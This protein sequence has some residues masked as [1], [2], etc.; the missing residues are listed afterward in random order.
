MFKDSAANKNA[1]E[2]A[3]LDEARKKGEL[4]EYGMVDIAAELKKVEEEMEVEGTK[5]DS[6]KDMEQPPSTKAELGGVEGVDRPDERGKG[7]S[8]LGSKVSKTEKDR[9][10]KKKTG[11]TVQ[12]QSQKPPMKAG[13]SDGSKE[14]ASEE[15]K[16]KGQLTG[17][18]AMRSDK[19][20]I[21]V[22]DKQN[23]MAMP[24]RHLRQGSPAKGPQRDKDGLKKEGQ[25]RTRATASRRA[26]PQRTI[27]EML[28]A[29]S[30][31]G[32]DSGED[33]KG[34]HSID[35][36]STKLSEAS[37]TITDTPNKAHPDAPSQDKRQTKLGH[38]SSTSPVKQSNDLPSMLPQPAND[39]RLEDRNNSRGDVMSDRATNE[40]SAT[41]L[42]EAPVTVSRRDVRPRSADHSG[43]ATS[44]S[45]DQSTTGLSIDTENGPIVVSD[46]TKLVTKTSHHTAAV[47]TQ[48]SESNQPNVLA[49]TIAHDKSAVKRKSSSTISSSDSQ[50]SGSQT[51]TTS[52]KLSSSTIDSSSTHTT[53]STQSSSTNNSSTR[54]YS[55]S[56]SS[57]SLSTQSVSNSSS[58]VSSTESTASLTVSKNNVDGN[59]QSGSVEAPAG[60]VTA[61]DSTKSESILSLPS[62]INHLQL[63]T[64]SQSTSRSSLLDRQDEDEV[65][66]LAESVHIVDTNSVVPLSGSSGSQDDGGDLAQRS[67]ASE[68]ILA[69]SDY[70]VSD[71]SD[72]SS[73]QSTKSG[74]K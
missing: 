6:S 45:F 69:T 60:H 56:N 10:R 43:A 39:I 41:H 26:V 47:K 32:S 18:H 51:L 17:K 68:N 30:S 35:S 70:S 58:S 22:I 74:N 49:T 7:Q 25:R 40:V 42:S 34:A 71:G 63:S 24:P 48:P 23:K 44:V 5:D 64:H 57:F 67:S 55:S 62:S 14:K 37:A 15:R 36:T 3:I 27:E 46:S 33:K 31:A 20:E 13:V 72:T 9:E 8:E 73:S 65:S 4:E 59:S 29:W 53:T 54:S 50:S 16:V 52:D 21:S 38:V 61:T 11:T 2:K 19:D 28:P 66:S 1:A 12:F